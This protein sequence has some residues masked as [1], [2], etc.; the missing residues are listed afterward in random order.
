MHIAICEDE[1]VQQ[2]ELYNLLQAYQSFF[3]HH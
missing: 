3:L 1:T 2:E